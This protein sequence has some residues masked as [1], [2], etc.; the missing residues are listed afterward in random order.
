MQNYTLE[1]LQL[2]WDEY[3]RSL[4]PEDYPVD[5]SQACWDNKMKN[6]NE[7]QQKVSEMISRNI[8]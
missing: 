7:V 2:L 8:K 1:N 5:L 3:K 6:I 4:H